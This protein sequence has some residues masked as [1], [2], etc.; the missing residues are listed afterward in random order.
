MR[1]ALVA[2]L[3]EN[4]RL[5]R[6]EAM[7]RVG[8]GL[9][10]GSAAMLLAERGALI[11]FWILVTLHG[12]FYMSIAK[13]NGG[14]FIDGYKPGFPLYLYY[15]RPVSTLSFVGFAMAYD[16]LTAVA[17]YLVCAAL[18]GAVFGKPLPL[19]SMT[20][21]LVTF[22]LAYLAVQWSTR[23]RTVQWIGSIVISWPPFFI[24]L[25]RTKSFPDIAFARVENL[26]MVLICIISVGFAVGGVA[27][28]R[29]GDAIASVPQKARS[30]GYPEWLINLLRFPCPTHSATRAQVWFELRSTG[31]PILVIGLSIALVVFL[32]Y[33]ISIF[34]APLRAAAVAAPIMFGIPALLFIFGGNAFG[35]RRKQGRRYVSTFE[36]TQ[37]YG[38]AQMAGLKILIRTAC[39]LA[40]LVMVGASVWLSGNLMSAW[41]SWQIEGKNTLPQLL[42]TRHKIGATFGALGWHIHAAQAV[43]L[44]IFVAATVATL[45]TIAAVLARYP[46]RLL[47]V[48][49]LLLLDGLVII[50]LAWAARHGFATG[51][52]MRSIIRATLWAGSIGLVCGTA[53]L[54]W[55]ALAENLLA[56]R[57]VFGMVILTAALGAAWVMLLSATG[58]SLTHM[59]AAEVIWVVSPALLPWIFSML[60]PWA[61]GR[62]RH[63]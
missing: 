33:A 31:L 61:L 46:R 47:M 19:F 20:M 60:A 30:A 45:A 58:V 32:L 38:T 15:A 36:A 5:T 21:L 35:I 50:L 54:A 24:L 62:V 42:E 11:A 40:A 59:S 14:R 3:W 26:L 1:S 63:T 8:L 57:L 39:V 55:R 29:C 16:S 56:P 37:P 52:L 9:V 51:F 48:G 43:V 44:A 53:F 4:W 12:F 13:L 23:N 6:V 41:G 7:Q 17:S 18:L 10:A 34:S 25:D 2:M 49:A 27:R 22:H 28:Q